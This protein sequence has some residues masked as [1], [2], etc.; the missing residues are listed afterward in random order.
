MKTS[1]VRREE[2]GGEEEEESGRVRERT[3]LFGKI[4]AGMN[5]ASRGSDTHNIPVVGGMICTSCFIKCWKM[6]TKCVSCTPPADA[7]VVNEA[8]SIRHRMVSL[9]VDGIGK[10]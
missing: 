3:T 1:N 2:G 5:R 10:N 9:R 6:S 8:T 7:S 4:M